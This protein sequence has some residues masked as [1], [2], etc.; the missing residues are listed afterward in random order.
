MKN[1]AS[2]IFAI[3]LIVSLVF[4]SLGMAPAEGAAPEPTLG[5]AQTD[6]VTSGGDD[7]TPTDEPSLTPTD[8]PSPTPTGEVTP[9]PKKS[10]AATNDDTESDITYE[11]TPQPAT[12]AEVQAA[13]DKADNA[14][15]EALKSSG[16]TAALD[17]LDAT[18]PRWEYALN[19]SL[20][21]SGYYCDK[22]TDDADFGAPYYTFFMGAV[23]TA[24]LDPT[25]L[26]AG[27]YTIETSGSDVILTNGTDSCVLDSSTVITVANGNLTLTVN[28]DVTIQSI[29]VSLSGSLTIDGTETLTSIG[30]V[31]ANSN[32]TVAVG[33]TLNT[34]NG[35][36][37]GGNLIVDG[38]L[39]NT[40]DAVWADGDITVSGTLSS[41]NG[42]YSGIYSLTGSFLID[43][44]TVTAN[45]NGENGVWMPGGGITV[46]NSGSLTTNGNTYPGI[47]IDSGY[48]LNIDGG[49]VTVSDNSDNGIWMAGGDIIVESGGTLTTNGNTY[50]GIGVTSGYNLYINGGTVTA[51]GNDS[52]GVWMP[53]GDII[54]DDGGTLTTEDNTYPG[55]WVVGNITVTDGGL[56]AVNSNSE[57]A[58]F[59]SQ[60]ITVGADG[61]LTGTSKY[62]IGVFA[63]GDI[64]VSGKLTGT[65]EDDTSGGTGV[66]ANGNIK[67]SGELTGNGSDYGVAAGGNI[68]VSGELTGNGS[69]NGVWGSDNITINTGG[70]LT[71]NGSDYG[72]WASGDIEVS[73]VL[74]SNEGS[75]GARASNDIT[76]Y[77]DGTLTSKGTVQGSDNIDIKEGGTLTSESGVISDNITVS[78]TLNN[79]GSNVWVNGDIT[80]SGT[81]TSKD[82]NHDGVGLS[83][84]LS[85]NGG[86]II[87]QNNDSNGVRVLGDITIADGG[88]MTAED[89]GQIDVLTFGNIT[90][91]SG[92]LTGTGGNECG[93]SADSG[94]VAISNGGIV[95]GAGVTYGVY[96]DGNITVDG[97]GS[98]IKGIAEIRGD[99]SN[100]TASVYTSN[101][102]ISATDGGIV[103]EEYTNT[104]VAFDDQ[105]AKNPY[106]DGS[107][108]ASI[109]NYD[110]TP[111]L[112]V[113]GSG[114]L[115]AR[116]YTGTQSITGTRTGGVTSETVSLDADSTHKVTL[117]GTLSTAEY[118]ITYKANG[119]NGNDIGVT[120]HASDIFNAAVN[121]FAAPDGKQFKEWNT[122]ANGTGTSYAAGEQIT[123]PG[124]NLILYAIWEN[125]PVQPTPANANSNTLTLQP[126]NIKAGQSFSFTAMGDRQYASG[127]VIGDERY[128]PTDWSVNPSGTF[129][130]G[131]PYTATA[132][133]NNVGTYT[134]TVN[135]RLERWDGSAWVDAM[136]PDIKEIEIIV[137]AAP[138]IYYTVTY[139]A[140][141]GTLTT[142]SKTVVYNEAYG[143]LPTPIRD[144]Y[145]FKGWYT[146][147]TGGTKVTAETIVS[148][149]ADHT[150]Y[151]Q[152]AKTATSGDTSDT[153]GTS[154]TTGTTAPST[155][156]SSNLWLWIALIGISVLGIAGITLTRKRKLFGGKK[157]RND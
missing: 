135:Y 21:P 49:E 155:G 103:W 78:G 123:M 157:H 40:G 139:N 4:S 99:G 143:S 86:T 109:G 126:D 80:V 105:T 12:M 140:N 153:D 72:V 141:G 20:M 2:R 50:P 149:D 63:A 39:N 91:N 55:V 3:L 119:G 32:L 144:G 18:K 125:I 56:T 25:S 93:I 124:S 115:A 11:Y 98:V 38:T 133:I 36:G 113:S 7:V 148:I 114:L 41:D 60:N 54:I 66:S 104:P 34:N 97:T 37:T 85:V 77:T 88:T 15:T 102:T 9:A 51:N 70:K 64:E 122:N 111:D 23:T 26:P 120:Y 131:G 112:T 6:E 92:T 76:I 108:I 52:N 19:Q 16:F 79:T 44:G 57:W 5:V 81:L 147:K 82:S 75:Y 137:L 27:S 46:K 121:T 1:K 84:N 136:N 58:V 128:V 29:F 47:Y 28:A 127:N 101:G 31:Y 118:T 154:K 35:A 96:V 73:G 142:T 42:Q 156:D 145:T 100:D 69:F 106:A 62:S 116:N 132:T 107:N 59:A 90:V 129:P 89:N 8:E 30:D 65:S 33:G 48:D 61:T 45:G 138:Q 67:V 17:A 146:E 22:V 24:L 110:W 14:Y 130:A 71:G 83:G 94:Y 95:T 87:V 151:A 53:G 68:E 74:T 117:T 150:L 43:G 13:I 152:W 10:G 134:L